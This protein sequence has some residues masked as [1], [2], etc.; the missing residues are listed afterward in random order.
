MVRLLLETRGMVLRNLLRRMGRAR[1]RYLSYLCSMTVFWLVLFFAFRE[2]FFFISRFRSVSEQVN[3]YLFSLFFLTLFVMLVI[4][5][6][7]LTYTTLFRSREMAFLLSKPICARDL[8]IYKFLETVFFSSWGFLLVATPLIVAYGLVFRCSAGFYLLFGLL[9]LPFTAI[10]AGVG[11]A[12]CQLVMRFLPTDRRVLGL[13]GGVLLIA[14]V[15]ALLPFVLELRREMTLEEG[16]DRFL[17]PLAFSRHPAQPGA[18]MTFALAAAARGDT[19]GALSWLPLLLLVALLLFLANTLFAGATLLRSF[20]R[21]QS[22]W[23]RRGPRRR[24]HASTPLGR[25]FDWGIGR[26]LGE[27]GRELLGKDVK[28]FLRT[29]AVWSQMLVFLGLLFLY[30]SNLSRFT[31]YLEQ[32]FYKN[33]VSFLNVIAVCFVMATFTTRF[34]Y[35]LLSLEGR[36]L[37]VLSLMPVGR[38]AI[39]WEKIFLSAAACLA[40]GVPLILLSDWRLET[41]PIL[42]VLHLFTVILAAFGLSGIAV[43]FGALLPEVKGGD[44]SQIAA[45]LGGS[46]TMIV[47]VLFS[48][49]L[50]G[51]EG[52]LCH[53]Y[54]VD[55]QM[56]E[57]EFMLMTTLIV[58]ASVFL[59]AVAFLVPMSLGIRAFERLEL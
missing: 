45:G 25:F 35:P 8:F 48:L 6:G 33:L 23:R 30:F 57:T 38:P 39:L 2:L 36:A 40:F 49:L 42:L 26:L 41:V 1:Y 12:I 5:N 59:S 46:L 34:V 53:L 7:I 18:W 47:S 37:W 52:Y 24:K 51:P 56:G 10:P 27:A 22:G 31:L 11:S 17:A 28:T 3:E 19:A 14:V 43:G 20:D 21:V 55:R 44:P 9:V 13:L 29:P 58:S 32:I 16:L 15:G 4:S 54:F 50:V